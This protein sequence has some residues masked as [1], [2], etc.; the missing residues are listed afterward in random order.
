MHQLVELERKVYHSR[1]V[2]EGECPPLLLTFP[3]GGH[4]SA[5]PGTTRRHAFLL[6]PPP[7]RLP[8]RSHPAPFFAVSTCCVPP[9]P[10]VCPHPTLH[11]QPNPLWQT[12]PANPLFAAAETALAAQ[13]DIL[14]NRIC[15]QFQ[16]LFGCKSL[17]GILPAM[18]KL[19]LAHT[20]RWAE[21]SAVVRSK[22]CTWGSGH[23]APW[24]T[25]KGSAVQGRA[26]ACAAATALHTHPLPGP[27]RWHL[28]ATLHPARTPTPPCAVR[29]IGCLIDC[30]GPDVPVIAAGG[31]GAGTRGHPGGLR[32]PHAAA[33]GSK[34]SEGARGW[35]WLG[36]RCTGDGWDAACT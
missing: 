34:V 22:C 29:S 12:L 5:P 30:R 16:R 10:R 32:Q 20:G 9:S 18:N 25:N 4:P 15:L 31:A 33:A 23:H 27:D 11:G 13:P 2:L 8:V 3:V 26:S 6:N 7:A 36:R 28:P 21:G 35:L 19:Y 1:E 24:A 14:I 17:Q